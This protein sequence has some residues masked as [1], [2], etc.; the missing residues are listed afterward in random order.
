MKK[1]TPHTPNMTR[2]I[3]R[4]F[5]VTKEGALEMLLNAKLN[6]NDQKT[7][8]DQAIH[9][10]ERVINSLANMG[11]TTSTLNIYMEKNPR[12]LVYYL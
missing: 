2:F 7:L 4:R 1:I 11:S 3:E 8:R 10:Y 6:E 12:P 5:S 9:T